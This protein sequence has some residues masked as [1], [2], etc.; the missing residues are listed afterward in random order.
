MAAY[1]SRIHALSSLALVNHTLH[2][3]SQPLLVKKV[4]VDSE[5]EWDWWEKQVPDAAV[6]ESLALFARIPDLRTLNTTGTFAALRELRIVAGYV[7]VH[8][9]ES[10]PREYSSFQRA[11]GGS[12]AQSS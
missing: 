9:L 12:D 4:L 2:Q 1:R 3:Y 10:L 7:E 6:I 8:Q 5:K 11:Q